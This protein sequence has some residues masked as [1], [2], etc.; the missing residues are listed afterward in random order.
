MNK[1]AIPVYRIR[2]IL[3][4]VAVA[5]A[6]VMIGGCNGG[7]TTANGSAKVWNPDQATKEYMRIQAELKL[8]GMEKPYLVINF[9]RKRL[10]I[11]LKGEVVWDLPLDITEGDNDEVLDFVERF[12]GSEPKLI[13]TITETYLFAAQEKTPDSILAIVSEAT[14]FKPDLLQREVPQRFQLLW[15][16]NV[17]LDI[18]S[19][20]KG[21]PVDK[22][23]TTIFEVRHAL[24]TPFGK[25]RLTIKLDPVKAITLYRVA[26]PGLPTM[27]LPPTK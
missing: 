9:A 15:G 27:V 4:A 26:Q 8:A 1:T 22:L 6:M 17:I 25:A 14:K 16:D 19:E 3:A 24:Q 2:F 10:M 23:K 18:R 11:K 5:I 20:V 21:K 13:R 7:D 12:Q